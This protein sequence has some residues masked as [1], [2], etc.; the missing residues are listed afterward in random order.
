MIPHAMTTQA[1]CS[2]APD[3]VKLRAWANSAMYRNRFRDQSDSFEAPGRGV[4]S[5][6]YEEDADGVLEGGGGS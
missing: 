3:T 4:I 2:L 5:F 6:E 1:C